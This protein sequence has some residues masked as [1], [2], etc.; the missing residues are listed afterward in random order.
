[1]L[2]LGIAILQLNEI[3][4]LQVS[5]EVGKNEVAVNFYPGRMVI[6]NG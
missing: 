6:I 4:K 3:G 2:Y 1:M 5:G